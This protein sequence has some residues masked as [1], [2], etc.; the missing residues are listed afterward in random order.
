M[1]IKSKRILHLIFNSIAFKE[2]FFLDM[3]S[4]FVKTNVNFLVTINDGNLVCA[5]DRTVNCDCGPPSLPLQ[6]LVCEVPVSYSAVAILSKLQSLSFE[7]IRM[8]TTLNSW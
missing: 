7:G 3:A 8:W 2:P 1:A 6:S 4:S 5:D